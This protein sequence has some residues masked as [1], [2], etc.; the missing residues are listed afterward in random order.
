MKFS[1]AVKERNITTY[2]QV[3]LISNDG[4]FEEW[5]VSRENLSCILRNNRPMLRAKGLKHKRPDWKTSSSNIP[6]HSLVEKLIAG[7]SS[8]LATMP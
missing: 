2:W 3:S 1:V 6:Y 5:K 8:K 4:N 7:I